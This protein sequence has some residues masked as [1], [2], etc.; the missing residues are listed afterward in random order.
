MI[1]AMV[2]LKLRFPEYNYR[3]NHLGLKVRNAMR[4][5]HFFTLIELLVVIAI[6]A[7]LAAMLLPAL[8]KARDRGRSAACVNNLKQLGSGLALYAGD[9]N[10][11]NSFSWPGSLQWGKFYLSFYNSLLAVQTRYLPGKTGV[12]PAAAPYDF[13]TT[14]TSIQQTYAGNY[15]PDDLRQLLTFYDPADTMSYFCYRLDRV[16]KEER[17]LGYRLPILMDSYYTT[18]KT[19]TYIVNRTHASRQV[20]LRHTGSANLLLYDGHAETV[21]RQK[22]KGA[23]G[24]NK[25]A[26]HGTVIDL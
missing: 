8:N 1:V 19:Q 5:N 7:I 13:L 20:D 18:D 14:G 22:L 4:R 10:G 21:N 24:W 3:G 16:P 9:Y 23:F 26:I 17:R 6:I 2:I 25:A 15:N 12:C 11:M